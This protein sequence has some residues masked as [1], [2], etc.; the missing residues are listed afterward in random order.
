MSSKVSKSTSKAAAKLD[1]CVVPK[2]IESAAPK[3]DEP[4]DHDHDRTPDPPAKEAGDASIEPKA[5]LD[6]DE[7]AMSSSSASSS[8]SAGS[9]LEPEAARSQVVVPVG[10]VKVLTTKAE[11]REHQ[12]RVKAQKEEEHRKLRAATE[13]N[14]A[15][16]NDRKQAEARLLAQKKASV[17]V[18]A[19]NATSPTEK[20]CPA[21]IDVSDD[22]VAVRKDPSRVYPS[23]HPDSYDEFDAA[24]V[25]DPDAADAVTVISDITDHDAR[26]ASTNPVTDDVG[27]PP[28]VDASF[29]AG[30]LGPARV[31]MAPGSEAISLNSIPYVSIIHYLAGCTFLDSCVLPLGSADITDRDHDEYKRVSAN[32]ARDPDSEEAIQEAYDFQLRLKNKFAKVDP[33]TLRVMNRPHG[34]VATKYP[35]RFDFTATKPK[36]PEGDSSNERVIGDLA[37]SIPTAVLCLNNA[38]PESCTVWLSQWTLYIQIM[39][40]LN[41]I[42]A[43]ID[44]CDTVS[45]DFKL[46][47]AN[48]NLPAH[49]LK[50]LGKIIGYLGSHVSSHY[51]DLKSWFYDIFEEHDRFPSAQFSSRTECAKWKEKCHQ[52]AGR[53]FLRW[54]AGLLLGVFAQNTTNAEILAHLLR[55]H[56]LFVEGIESFE[57]GVRCPSRLLAHHL[58]IVN[59]FA[60][61]CI[62][63]LNMLIKNKSRRSD[64]RKATSAGNKRPATSLNTIKD[65]PAAKKPREETPKEPFKLK[66]PLLKDPK[67][68]EE[69]REFLKENGLVDKEGRSTRRYC[70]SCG[71]PAHSSKECTEA[72]KVQNDTSPF[73]P[74]GPRK[75][76][77]SGSK[78]DYRKKK[79]SVSFS[80]I[81]CPSNTHLAVLESEQVNTPANP[82]DGPYLLGTLAVPNVTGSVTLSVLIDSGAGSNFISRKFLSLFIFKLNKNLPLATS[83]NYDSLLIPISDDDSFSV[84]YSNGSEETVRQAVDLSIEFPEIKTQLRF[85]VLETD[86]ISVCIGYNDAKALKLLSKIEESG[87]SKTLEADEELA[88]RAFDTRTTFY[89]IETLSDTLN[90]I[91]FGQDFKSID[92]LKGL[93]KEY[94]CLFENNLK[95]R[96][97]HGTHARIHLVPDAKLT[98]HKLRKFPDSLEDFVS[99]EMKRLLENDV[100]ERSYAQHYCGIVPV[101]KGQ[102]EWRICQNYVQLNKYTVDEIHPLPVISSI[103]GKLKDCKYFAKMDLRNGFYQI[104]IHPADRAKTAFITRDGLFQF[105][106]MPFGLKNAPAIFQKTM[107]SILAGLVDVN[108][109]IYIDDLLVYGKTEDELINNLRLVFERLKKYNVALKGSKCSFGLT[110]LVYLGHVINEHGK[111]L[112]EERT[113]KVLALRT[114]ASFSELRTALGLAAAFQEYVENYATLVKPLTERSGQKSKKLPFVWTPEMDENWTELKKRIQNATLLFRLDKDAPLLVRTDASNKG[115]GAVLFQ[116][117][118]NVAQPIAYCSQA[119]SDVA[120]RWSTYEQEA[121]GCYFAFVKWEDKLLGRKFTLESDHKNLLYIKEHSSAKVVRWRMYMQQFNFDFFHVPG[122]ENVIADALSRLLSI[123]LNF[124]GVSDDDDG[125]TEGGEEEAEADQDDESAELSYEEAEKIFKEFHNSKIG[126][127]SIAITVMLASDAGFC[128]KNIKQ[129]A[130]E[131]VSRCIVCQ[132]IK[133]GKF[134]SKVARKHTYSSFPFERIIIDALGP[135][136]TCDGY[137]YI[138]VATCAFTRFV[139]LAPA[140]AVGAEDAA[141]FIAT[142]LIGRYGAPTT[143]QTDGATTFRNGLISSLLKYHNINHYVSVAYHPETNGI[144]ERKNAEVMKHLR[145]LILTEDDD[146]VQKIPIVQRILN[147]TTTTPL[148][149]YPARLLFGDNFLRDNNSEEFIDES[150]SLCTDEFIAKQQSLLKEIIEASR[151]Y[152]IQ[153]FEKQIA[154]TDR[155]NRPGARRFGIGSFVLLAYPEQPPHKILAPWMGPMK[156]VSIKGDVVGVVNLVTGKVKEVHAERIKPLEGKFSED[157]ERFAARDYIGVYALKKIR[158][159]HNI[160][161]GPS[162]AY[163]TVEWIGYD[164]TYSATYDSL[165]DNSVFHQYVRNHRLMSRDLSKWIPEKYLNSSAGPMELDLDEDGA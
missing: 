130:K 25:D 89:S 94:L 125:S 128:F 8:D 107:E 6:D 69:C 108:C 1:E 88:E 124:L 36:V 62:S 151:Q 73:K 115:V 13:R 136:N 116:I 157:Y 134:N 146:W 97:I 75:S 58:Q 10:K 28:T 162:G 51:T 38:T 72:K 79:V 158:Q 133:T 118:D 149:T 18:V 24:A 74:W 132:K 147:F 141:Y 46:E 138:F 129:R 117:I 41:A 16:A 119:F 50:S 66:T 44:P 68:I 78:T 92:K 12:A 121:Y 35:C 87:V 20:Q 127:H 33:T 106:R 159:A 143:I 148:N 60:T 82:L 15:I 165:K 14:L 27:V 61:N 29:A 120:S 43:C 150:G 54:E 34:N 32:L 135:L 2:P 161:K 105:K 7:D 145:A 40:R 109:S 163:F 144:T 103:L 160:K 139:E 81:S 56:F 84:T 19:A 140:K 42:W 123:N 112:S 95:D 93:V 52:A 67:S 156:V 154:R 83:I 55:R 5:T 111:R 126:H 113:E 104:Q 96:Y 164:G 71:S 152:Q 155:R 59:T 99:L 131:F 65:G 48:K 76:E 91:H 4:S 45:A 47:L 110:E 30:F 17:P 49:G 122:T 64:E 11:F 153:H 98:K 90:E 86:A 23:P 100:I 80:F 53:I 114:P 57:N 37:K 3:P 137:N 22:K 77:G 142:A 21:V 9:G 101:K 39:H 26:P 102:G 31:R 85:Y 70:W 63:N